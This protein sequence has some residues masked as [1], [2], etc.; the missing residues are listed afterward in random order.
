MFTCIL[1]NLAEITA[2][3]NSLPEFNFKNTDETSPIK[4]LAIM[5]RNGNTIL[6]IRCKEDTDTTYSPRP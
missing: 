5:F 4:S 3:P 1:P 2:E 6:E